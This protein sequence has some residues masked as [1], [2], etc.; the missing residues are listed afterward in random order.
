MRVPARQLHRVEEPVLARDLRAR[1]ASSRIDG[2]GGSYGVER[3]TLY[4][5]L[6]EMGP[7]DTISWE[8]PRGDQSWAIEFSEFVEDI[9]EGREPD[10]GL[11]D[12][13]RAGSRRDHLRRS[14]YATA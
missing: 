11:Q 7:P 5:M 4:Q 1:Q 12:A 6:P 13:R 2:L 3:L 14:G 10:P 9:H 8:F